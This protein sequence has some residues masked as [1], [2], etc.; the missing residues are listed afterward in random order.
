[1]GGE[2]H[3]AQKIISPRGMDRKLICIFA[4][5]APSHKPGPQSNPCHGPDSLSFRA[6]DQS[7]KV[8]LIEPVLDNAVLLK[9]TFGKCF[10]NG[11]RDFSFIS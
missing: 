3:S 4:A 5:P 11:S 9:L 10:G 7:V 6:C 1:M 2:S 8:A